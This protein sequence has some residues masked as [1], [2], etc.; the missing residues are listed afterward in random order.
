MSYE[1][2]SHFEIDDNIELKGNQY[3]DWLPNLGDATYTFSGRSAIELAILD[4]KQFREIKSCYMPSY[5]CNSM[6]QP[7]IKNNINVEFYEVNFSEDVGL[8]YD[9]DKNKNCDIFFAMSYFGLE[10]YQLDD[11]IQ[12][13]SEQNKIIIEDITH[14]LL[15]QTSF[16]KNAD[17]CIASLRKWFPVASGGYITK[18][19]GVLYKKPNLSSERLV[20][21]KIKAMYSKKKYLEG[22]DI[23]KDEF[24]QSFKRFE[25]IIKDIDSNYKIDDFSLKI[26]SSIDVEDVR[27][28]RRRNAKVLYEGINMYSNIAPLIPLPDFEENTPLFVPIVLLD[29]KR[30]DLQSALIKNDIY[31][32]IHWP[33]EEYINS[34]IPEIELSL[35]CDQRYSIQDM[36]YI[37]DVI[38]Q[39]CMKQM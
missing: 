15:S 29:G 37:L 31:C 16:S 17:Y 24:L 8:T 33:Q 38:N 4:I 1:I 36:E 23:S 5:C 19:N 20:N 14:R 34:N 10:I 11:V 28:K 9:I 7:F 6:L 30:D 22:N 39:W 12:K 2:G 26:I 35:I 18:N 3:T 32:P 13:F 21:E 25:L 27:L